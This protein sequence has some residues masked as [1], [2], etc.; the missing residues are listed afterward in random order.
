M[1]GEDDGRFKAAWLSIA[2]SLYSQLGPVILS[3]DC[4]IGAS[5]VKGEAVLQSIQEL[6]TYMHSAAY[7]F[8][9]PFFML[10]PGMFEALIECTIKLSEDTGVDGTGCPPLEGGQIS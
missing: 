1:N 3:F 8:T 7:E 9:N 10:P 5:S 2:A 6:F 4:R